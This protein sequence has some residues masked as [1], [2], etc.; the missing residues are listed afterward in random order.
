VKLITDIDYSSTRHPPLWIMEN[1]F[2]SHMTEKK[3]QLQILYIVDYVAY[4]EA[5]NKFK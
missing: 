5:K 3:I 1:V 2:F 4:D